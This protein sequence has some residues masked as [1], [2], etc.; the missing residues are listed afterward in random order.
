VF[1]VALELQASAPFEF[2]V[3]A[4]E[5]PAGFGLVDG[6][7]ATT[8]FDVGA[9]SIHRR[10]LRVRASGHPGDH[11]WQTIVRVPGEPEPVR[12]AGRVVVRP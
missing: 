9:G 6:E 3:I 2:V 7:A 10:T 11:F 8:L 4:H 5:L 12:V 1:E